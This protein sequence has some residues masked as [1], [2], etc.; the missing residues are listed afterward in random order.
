MSSREVEGVLCRVDTRSL[1]LDK[2]ML[3]AYPAALHGLIDGGFELGG[4]GRQRFT[5]LLRWHRIT[6]SNL[7]VHVDHGAEVRRSRLVPQLQKASPSPDP[8]S[9]M[10][11]SSRRLFRRTARITRTGQAAGRRR[12]PRSGI[13]KR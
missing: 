9:F 13:P 5:Q 1:Q 8:R 10:L 2:G 3:A 6:A 11:D 4:S 12:K 7:A